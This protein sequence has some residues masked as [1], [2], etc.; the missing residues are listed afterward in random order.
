MDQDWPCLSARDPHRDQRAEAGVTAKVRDVGVRRAL[1][2]LQGSE[3]VFKVATADRAGE[4]SNVVVASEYENLSMREMHL[5][6]DVVWVDGLRAPAPASTGWHSADDATEVE[7]RAGLLAEAVS[8]GLAR[9]LGE[10]PDP[11]EPLAGLDLSHS[12]QQAVAAL[13]MSEALV[14]TGKATRI[15]SFALGPAHDAQQQL[16][17]LYVEAPSAGVVPGMRRIQGVRPAL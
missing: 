15:D 3:A 6:G 10:I 16:E 1:E 13:L 14:G 8:V 12:T 11:L 4:L 7:L 2:R 17:L 5:R 9:G